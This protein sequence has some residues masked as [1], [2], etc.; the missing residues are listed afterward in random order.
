MTYT[1]SLK[2]PKKCNFDSLNLFM[3]KDII[4]P[5]VKDVWVAAALTINEV[6]EQQWDIYII[7]N[8]SDDIEGVLVSARGYGS[9]ENDTRKTDTFR[10]FLKTI[11]AQ[12]SKKVEP[13]SEEVFGINNEYWLS[14][15]LNGKLY[16]KK[17]IFLAE[18]IKDEH[19]ISLPIVDKK[20]VLIK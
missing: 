17:Y 18:T 6:N 20:G 7:N 1:S 9:L 2:L 4:V 3:N 8:K 5:I 10:H 11:K 13:I 15:F 19:L 14:F 12:S 16:D